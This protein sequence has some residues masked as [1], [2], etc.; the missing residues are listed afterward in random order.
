VKTRALLVLV[1]C[2]G[3][4]APRTS[5]PPAPADDEPAVSTAELDDEPGVSTAEPADDPAAIGLAAAPPPAPAPALTSAPAPGPEVWLR[6]STHVHARPSG[7]STTP[8]PDVMRWYES[9]GYDWIALT[10]HNRISEVH[11][12]TAGHPAAHAPAKGLIV[13]AGIE[14]TYNPARCLPKGDASGRCRIHVNLLGSTARPAG[15]VVWGPGQRLPD[16]RLAKYQAALDL[17]KGLGGLSQLNHPQWYWGMTGDLLA[18]LARRGM[19]LVEIANVQFERWNKGD[20]THPSTEAL[21]DA[22][23][24]QGVTLWG[25]ASDDAHSFDGRGR[26]PAGGGW[27]AV[28]ARRDPQAIV[29]ALAA[30][31]FYSST[32]VVLDRAEVIA[33]ELVVEIA[34]SER[35]AH[36]IEFVEN[37]KRVAA[38]RDRSARRALPRTGYV[39]AVV[40]RDDGKRAWV[41]PARL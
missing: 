25:V 34:A 21:W 27:V 30:G 17:Q 24:A 22:A 26:W 4:D 38:V 8:I 9:R 11:G 35:L 31:R 6:G 39:R 16:T 13:L 10:D 23:L 28:K 20:G 1:A 33:G 15:K 36:T 18:E 12:A 32:G 5:A 29:N 40:T 3:R 7:D 2:A 37:G 19:R 14:L 41:Q